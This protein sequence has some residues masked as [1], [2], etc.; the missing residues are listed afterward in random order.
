MTKSVHSFKPPPSK[1]ALTL[2]L[3]KTQEPMRVY[4]VSLDE[5]S[6]KLLR[7]LGGGNLSAGIRLAANSKL[8]D[9]IDHLEQL[10]AALDKKYE[11]EHAELLAR[12]EE[13]RLNIRDKI[14][15]VREATNMSDSS[16]GE[17]ALLIKEWWNM[18]LLRNDND[19]EIH[20]KVR[21][22][23]P[24]HGPKRMKD[25]RER[26]QELGKYKVKIKEHPST[27]MPFPFPEPK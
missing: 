7:S 9:D 17:A 21:A 24:I 11:K 27:A 15:S 25:I 13:E 23:W 3:M 12:I 16:E 22:G 14:A 2:K 20:A 6:V 26:L 8:S 5:I 18:I 10:D 1:L 4:T 19:A